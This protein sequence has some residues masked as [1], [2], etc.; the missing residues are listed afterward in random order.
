M[1]PLSSIV[2]RH[3][4]F[5]LTLIEVMVAITIGLILLVALGSMLVG[6][7]KHFKVSDEFRAYRRM[8]P[9]R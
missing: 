1:A 6:S 9:S 3:R 4:Q 8:V 5:G 7:I 2:S